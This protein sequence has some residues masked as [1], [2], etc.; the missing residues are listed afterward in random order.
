MGDEHL[1][2]TDPMGIGAYVTLLKTRKI[3][4]K[5]NITIIPKDIYYIIYIVL[6]DGLNFRNPP[7]G[8]GRCHSV[9]E[10]PDSRQQT[11]T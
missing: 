1:W 4:Y 8:F 2:T 5:S 9:W 11:Q 10:Y 3:P 6:I 7:V